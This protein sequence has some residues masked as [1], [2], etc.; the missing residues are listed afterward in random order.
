MDK[1]NP[2]QV[3]RRETLGLG[4]AASV[5]LAGSSWAR[6]SPSSGS[7]LQSLGYLIMP[8][9]DLD[10]WSVWAPKVFALQIADSSSSTRAFRMDDHLY[11]LV[12]DQ[13]VQLPTFG[14]E[15]AN[16]KALDAMASRIEAAGIAVVKGS[17]ALIS[18]RGVRDL[19]TLTDPAGFGLEIFHGPALANSPFQPSRAISGFRTG[20]LGMGHALVG[21]APAQFDAT[22]AF[23]QNVLGFRVSDYLASGLKAQFMH[24]NPRHHSLAIGSFGR[25]MV[26]HIMMEMT[27]FDDVGE[28]YDVALKEYKSM[29][30]WGLGRH[31]NDLMTSFYTNTP[32]NFRMECGWGGLLVDPERWQAAELKVGTSIWGHGRVN[33]MPPQGAG[34]AG[35][36]PGGGPPGGGPPGGGPPGGGPPGGGP[37]GGGPQGP[38][39]KPLRAP[40]QVYGAN[41]DLGQRHTTQVLQT[42]KPG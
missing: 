8:G 21:V 7:G 35:G 11:R 29:I 41:Y 28:S 17:S 33:D 34:F 4:A 23:Y 15:V 12:I 16:A 30:S 26:D 19:V 13:K 14:W 40:L 3:T 22:T 31:T 27:F 37:P 6:S 25:S 18:Q 36:P 38:A 42:A 20:Q 24:I 10:A 2:P 39:L 9:Q 32:S 5:A 1:Q